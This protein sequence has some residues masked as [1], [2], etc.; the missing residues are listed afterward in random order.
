[1]KF[2]T[3]TH[4]LVGNQPRLV[5]AALFDTAGEDRVLAGD[6]VTVGDVYDN[7]G[8]LRRAG[9]ELAAQPKSAEHKLATA[10]I[11]KISALEDYA[12]VRRYAVAGVSDAGKLV[13]YTVKYETALK[14]LAG[15]KAAEAALAGEAEA[16]GQSV[17]E[18]AQL[19]KTLGD[20][21]RA[22]GL[23][24]DA[25]YQTHKAAILRLADPRAVE[26]YDFSEG[27]P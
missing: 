5:V 26:A 15:D 18:L 14:T 24:I 17:A 22:A 6:S 23:K 12:A 8:F 20:A 9:V 21:W 27:W 4:E 2:A 16:R 10:K 25:A 7:G 3:L 13:V 1:M 11:E 19:V